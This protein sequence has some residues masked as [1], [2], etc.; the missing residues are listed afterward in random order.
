MK[1]RSLAG[2]LIG[3]AL[4]FAP[5]ATAHA[6]EDKMVAIPMP[7]QTGSLVLGTGELPGATAPESWHRQYGKNF[8]RNV[9]VA[10]LTPFLPD[11]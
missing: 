11:P 8:A 9:T 3:L 6:Q 7:A 10:T 5:S 4:A 1:S 2:K